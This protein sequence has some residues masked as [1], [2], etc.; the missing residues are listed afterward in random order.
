MEVNRELTELVVRLQNGDGGAFEEIYKLTSGKAFAT[1]LSIVKNRDDAEDLLQDA[2]VTVLNKINTL[3][4]PETFIGWFNIIVA[5]KAKNFLQKSHPIMFHDDEDEELVL[6]SITDEDEE[7]KPGID[8]EKE[9][10]RKDVMSLINN[11]SDEKKTVILLYYYDNMSIKDISQALEINENTV[12]SRMLQAKKDLTKG[13]KELEKKNRSVLGVAPIPLVIWA[14]KSTS[15]S[16]A[17]AFAG[18]AASVGVLGAVTTATGAGAAVVTSGTAA[19]GGIAA[20]SILQKVI[21]GIAAAGIVTGAAVGTKTVIDHKKA[22]PETTAVAEMTEEISTAGTTINPLF[23]EEIEPFA[24]NEWYFNDEDNKEIIKQDTKLEK[25]IHQYEIK[26]EKHAFEANDI[27]EVLE[28]FLDAFNFAY[29]YDNNYDYK[30][31][32]ENLVYG[33]IRDP[34]C[35]IYMNSVEEIHDYDGKTDPL[36]KFGESYSRSDLSNLKW[37][38]KNIFNVNEDKINKLLAE[39]EKEGKIYIQDNYI[40]TEWGGVGGWGPALEYKKV[41][42]DGEKMNVIYT[43]WWDNSG[44][45]D[46]E[47]TEPKYATLSL[48]KIGENYY[49]SLYKKGNDES[50][51][52]SK[53]EDNFDYAPPSQKRITTT[54]TTMTT[55]TAKSTTTVTA[56]ADTT[57]SATKATTVVTKPTTTTTITTTAAPA[58]IIIKYVVTDGTGSNGT[59]TK[60]FPDGSTVT[61]SDIITDDWLNEYDNKMIRSGTYPITVKSGETYEYTVYVWNN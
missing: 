22:D 58:Y 45:G 39:M 11:L 4:K 33:L 52:N 54:T 35:S 42:F 27:P 61:E 3:E 32:T 47:E 49:W 10:L 50:Y 51:L 57:T 17:A 21:I 40:Y 36:G 53:Y 46:L 20:F 14:L 12:K 41:Y 9:E 56:E 2:Y 7:Y 13:V 43:E 34:S 1:A 31:P 28:K 44:M 29:G 48:K 59:I 60:R 24:G 55:V 23:T 6:G 19:V 26:G 5:N 38:T 25:S 8:V 15:G 30:N 37:I 16:T 18:S